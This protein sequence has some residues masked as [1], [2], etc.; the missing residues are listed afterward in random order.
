[1][2][3]GSDSEV[4]PIGKNKTQNK[5]KKKTTQQ[6]EN[7][8]TAKQG[9]PEHNWSSKGRIS[10]P[11]RHTPTK[12]TRKDGSHKM[13][14]KTNQ[15]LRT[16]TRREKI[17]PPDQKPTQKPQAKKGTACK[18]NKQ[19]ARNQDQ[20]PSSGAE[21]EIARSRQTTTIGRKDQKGSHHQNP[22]RED[23]RK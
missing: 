21:Q 5:Q 19:T 1:V 10:E 9:R 12:A 3:L 11:R 4:Q 14:E 20:S 13:S 22:H 16:Q 15:K 23:N 2:E 17:K 8:N 6:K 18:S 7:P